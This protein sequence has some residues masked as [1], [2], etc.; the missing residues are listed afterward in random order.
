[1]QIKPANWL[2][3]ITPWQS[4]GMM[5]DDNSKGLGDFIRMHSMW[6]HEITGL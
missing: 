5:K 1:M 2:T 3:E 4:L 6:I